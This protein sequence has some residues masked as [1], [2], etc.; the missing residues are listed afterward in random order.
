MPQEMLPTGDHPIEIRIHF[1]S[2]AARYI[3]SRVWH[4]SQKIELKK[5][6]SVILSIKIS[7]GKELLRW[8]LSFGAS[9]YVTKPSFLRERVF[10]EAQ[11][12]LLLHL[13]KHSKT[14]A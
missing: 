8:I 3:C 10:N 14:A 1:S 4:E 9:A 11:Q 2:Q 6:G 5:N 7:D 13:K 12:V